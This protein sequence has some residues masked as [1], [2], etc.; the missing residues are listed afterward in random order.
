MRQPSPTPQTLANNDVRVWDIVRLLTPLMPA[1]LLIGL[2]VWCGHMRAALPQS[3]ALRDPT[4]AVTLITGLAIALAIGL[5]AAMLIRRG[6]KPAIFDKLALGALAMLV[7][8]AWAWIVK[9][10]YR[11]DIGIPGEWVW[12][13]FRNGHQNPMDRGMSYLWTVA[14]MVALMASCVFFG[15]KHGLKRRSEEIVIVALCLGIALGITITLGQGDTTNSLDVTQPVAVTVAP[16]RGGYYAEAV[17]VTDMDAYLANYDKMIAE[18]QVNYL[19][20]G[21]IADHPAGPVLFH[22]LV[23]RAIEES[24]ALCNSLPPRNGGFR[25]QMTLE[26]QK[27]VSLKDRISPDPNTPSGIDA[28]RTREDLLPL[29]YGEFAGIWGSAFLFRLA[30]CAG[31]IPIYLLGRM[32]VDAETGLIALCLSAL[33]PSLQIFSPYGDQIFVFVA[34]WAFLFWYLGIKKKNLFWSAAA[35]AM[36]CLGMHWSLSLLLA[37]ALVGMGTLIIFFNEWR[38]PDNPLNWKGW[39]KVA[40]GGLGGFLL[41]ALL[42]ML[43]FDYHTFRVWDIC[44]TQHAT[45]AALFNKSYLPW[46]LFNPIEFLIFT[47]MPVACLLIAQ[48]GADLKDLCRAEKRGP[49]PL[50][51]WA[52]I[53]VLTVINF[54]GKNLGEIARLWMFLMPFAALA[55][56]MWTKRL[57]RDRGWFTVLLILVMAT[58]TVLFKLYLDVFHLTNR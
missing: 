43:F 42:P 34:T 20:R 9:S 19:V 37:V 52:L 51:P 54:S 50:M 40:G 32:L 33:I 26:V 38:K 14:F 46:L 47:G 48:C 6:R 1:A 30:F 56:A 55:A 29:T 36:L 57:M 16:S 17:R 23:N 7:V 44:L 3:R 18:L 10:G 22:W 45:F 4:L 2:V 21:H 11:W 39:A 58:Q 27:M 5:A 13:Y 8:G 53:G 15:I 31:L 28:P 12:P 41:I 24:P 25:Q 49:L 35:G